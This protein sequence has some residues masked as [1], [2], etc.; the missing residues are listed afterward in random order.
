MPK[1]GTLTF[2]T[3]LATLDDSFPGVQTGE[4]KVA[5][6]ARISVADTGHGMSKETLERA[7]EPFFTTKSRSKGTGLGL[8]MVYALAKQSGGTVRLYSEEGYGTIVSIYLPVAGELRPNL[9]VEPPRHVSLMPGGTVLVVDDEAELLEIAHAYLAEMGFNVICADGPAAALTA[10][11]Q[12]SEID[13]MVTDIIMSGGMNGVELAAEARRLNPNLKVIY[14]SGFPADAL[15][16]RSGTRVDAPMLRKP[17]Q[18]GDFDFMIQQ[19]MDDH[20]K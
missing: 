7:L 1:G 17:Y 8:A 18:R 9:P 5:N 3:Q 13:L 19:A 11:E 6:Y 16:D 2:G 14:S 10:R 12:N 20:G 15:A 4:L